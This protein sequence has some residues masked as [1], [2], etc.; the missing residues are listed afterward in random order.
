V[1]LGVA[2]SKVGVVVNGPSLSR[3]DP[4]RHPRRAFREDG[5]LRLI[6]AGA[7]TPIY[8]LD[9]AIDAVARIATERP[10]LDARLEVYG[11]GDSEPGLRAHAERL[12][13]ADRVDFHGRIPIDEVPAAVATAD[14]GLAPTRQDRFTD[15][16]LS[17]KL[18][19]YAAMGKPVVATRL[20]MVERTFPVGTVATYAPGD[21]VSMAAAIVG[22]ADDPKAREA[23]VAR[24][25][26]IV[27]AGSWEHEAPAYV[28]LVEELIRS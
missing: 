14:I 15:M 27:E 3:F 24:G 4:S 28:A 22:L 7:L 9:V 21:A 19:E 18:F 16:S 17:T 23:A 5:R 6:Y 12:G 10:D 26:T 2:P 25:A 11:R 1:G 13:V 8:E 20:P